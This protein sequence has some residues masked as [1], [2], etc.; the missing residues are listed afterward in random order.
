M[1][2][3]TVSLIVASQNSSVSTDAPGFVRSTTM[4]TT[5]FPLASEYAL[6]GACNRP[7]SVRPPPIHRSLT[8][9]LTQLVYVDLLF[10]L[11]LDTGPISEIKGSRLLHIVFDWLVKELRYEAALPRHLFSYEDEGLIGSGPGL[12]RCGFSTRWLRNI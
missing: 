6:I 1:A 7:A 5:N 9:L 4:H 2:F 8:D 10:F 12:C 3:W 11:F